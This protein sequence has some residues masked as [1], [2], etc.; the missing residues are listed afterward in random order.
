MYVLFDNSP[1]KESVSKEPIWIFKG[2]YFGE[3]EDLTEA[4]TAFDTGLEQYNV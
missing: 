1:L 3:K 4:E 2:I